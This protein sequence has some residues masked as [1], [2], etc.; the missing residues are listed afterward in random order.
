MSDSTFYSQA[1]NFVSAVQGGVDPRTGLMTLNF[2]LG[3]LRNFDGNGPG[4]ALR[5]VYS[6]QNQSDTFNLGTGISLGL[7][8]Y[9]EK[10]RLLSLSSGEQYKTNFVNG[11]GLFTQHKLDSV[12]AE[13]E[14]KIIWV[15]TKSGLMERLSLQG[16]RF[17]VT[18]RIESETGHWLKLTWQAGEKPALQEVRGMDDSLLCQ[19][20]YTGGFVNITFF[21]NG[22]PE[23]NEKY[24][25]ILT[26]NRKGDGYNASDY[27]VKII[28]NQLS[29][30][31][32]WTLEYDFHNIFLQRFPLCKISY[33]TGLTEVA[34]YGEKMMVGTQQGLA[35]FPAVSRFTR[36]PG[37]G[38]P[39][40]NT[41]YRYSQGRNYL[42]G[43][44]AVLNPDRD[45]VYEVGGG[46][47]YITYETDELTKRIT[48][49]EYNNF[50]LQV[51]EKSE[52]QG[53]ITEH[54]TTFSLETGV[55]FEKQPSIFQLPKQQ[56]VSYESVGEKREETSSFSYDDYGNPVR[57]VSPDGNIVVMEYDQPEAPGAFVKYIK[58]RTAFPVFTADWADEFPTRIEYNYKY[59]KNPTGSR[60]AL[61]KLLALEK[62]YT[63][64]PAN[65]S[66]LQKIKTG[67]YTSPSDKDFKWSLQV[68]IQHDYYEDSADKNFSLLKAQTNTLYARDDEKYISSQDIKYEVPSAGLRTISKTTTTHDKLTFTTSSNVSCLTGRAVSKTDAVGNRIEYTYDALGRTTE[69]VMHPDH[70]DYRNSETYAY[71]L[72]P[73]DG[74]G[75]VTGTGSPMTIHKDIHNNETRVSYDGMGRDILHE[76]RN[77]DAKDPTAWHKVSETKWDAAGRKYEIITYDEIPVWENGKIN[78][79]KVQNTLFTQTTEWDKW[80]MA[81]RVS[82]SNGQVHYNN[83]D[84]VALT[85]TVWMSDKNNTHESARGVTTLNK[86]SKRPVKKEICVMKNDKLSVYSTVTQVWDG[87][88]RLRKSTDEVGHT[89]SW[90][91]DLFGRVY[92]TTYPDGSAVTKTYEAFSSAELINGISV[93]PVG[94]PSISL[95]LQVFDGLGRLKSTTSG[96]RNTTFTYD[97]P[98]QT[99]PSTQ[100]GPDKVTITH[101]PDPLLGGAITSVTANN[102]SQTFRYNLK[103][104]QMEKAFEGA[105]KNTCSTFNSYP[106]GR[107]Q[108][109]RSV[110]LEG[111]AVDTEW[112][113]SLIGRPAVV[114]GDG[115]NEIREYQSN[116]RL[117]NITD[118]AVKVVLS[119][120]ELGRLYLWE[121][122]EKASQAVLTTK[123]TFD[124]YGREYTRE[125][126]HSNG[127]KRSIRQEWYKNNQL[128][129][130]FHYSA[131]TTPVLTEGY[132]YDDRNRLET[133]TCTG[134]ELPSDP[135]GNKFTQQVYEF[136]VQNNITVCRTTLA[137]GSVNE[138]RYFFKNKKDPCQLSGVTNG[139]PNRAP[140]ETLPELNDR[141]TPQGYPMVI[142]LEY[143]DAGRMTKDEEGRTLTYDSLGRLATITGGSYGYD[144]RNRMVY[145]KVDK[146]Q[147]AHRL[148]YRANRLIEEWV[149]KGGNQ[150]DAAKDSRVRLVYAAGGCVA[151]AERKEN[152]TEV[153]LTG[154]DAKH[155]VVV[156]LEKGE[157]KTRVY[158]PYGYAKKDNDNG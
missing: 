133:Y 121:A 26:K 110:W 149:T 148:Y 22:K 21:P 52:L 48:T 64:R 61:T 42:G 108:T 98:W 32:G 4:L 28:N 2:P 6:P 140:E 155:S 50:H 81:C 24:T 88:G 138:A 73:A 126:I 92:A 127:T 35:S 153:M 96:G 27:L 113:Y 84:P 31:Q 107:L 123:L 62:H 37:N 12:H 146:M 90:N 11:K 45:T 9:D 116:G 87:M 29:T 106:S 53:G 151:Q 129:G 59:L 19:L 10:S 25:I 82:N 111:P 147:S 154:T 78:P 77:P 49:R 15:T 40:M 156:S 118:D 124:A 130:R 97:H 41:T 66:V 117:W 57:M 114:N 16:N 150:P 1:Y 100:T 80:G 132:T 38:Q 112:H 95:G 23:L 143:D 85:K 125:M 3:T 55:V 47:T 115:V 60:N 134:A 103:T 67:Q 39:A 17:Y 142:V 34:T 89:T 44:K 14:D 157:T 33:P 46:Y 135:Y 13:K 74:H 72:P 8:T 122:T 91:Y 105:E 119:Y 71:F 36:I 69:I 101:V 128:S 145:Q 93:T 137:N 94:K 63:G 70:P 102:I 18:D 54:K 58:N 139:A 109:E 68:E 136:D 43:G 144:A 83:T 30:S 5:L 158:T 79:D 56:V 76:I 65:D 75:V 104:G 131:D 86:I 20:K 99:T 120:D 7:S 141:K 152:K 51:S